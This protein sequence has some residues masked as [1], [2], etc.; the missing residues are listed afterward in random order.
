MRETTEFV[1]ISGEGRRERRQEGRDE[2][3][4][5][6]DGIR[7]EAQRVKAISMNNIEGRD[8]ETHRHETREKEMRG[9]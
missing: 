2:V 5:T 1:A 4:S 3:D 8:Q 6:S 7:F 9:E